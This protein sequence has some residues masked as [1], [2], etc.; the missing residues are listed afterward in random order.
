MITY[1]LAGEMAPNQKDSALVFVLAAVIEMGCE[2]LY[3]FAHNLLLIHVRVR[4]EMVALGL[5]ACVIAAWLYMFPK[6]GLYVCIADCESVCD[7]CVALY[8]SKGRFVCMYS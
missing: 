3:I 2:P 6:V 7:C 5:R 8:V 4:V 1:I